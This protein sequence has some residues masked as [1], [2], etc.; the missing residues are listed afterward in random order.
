MKPEKAKKHLEARR[1]EKYDSVNLI[2]ASHII[3]LETFVAPDHEDQYVRVKGYE[4][5]E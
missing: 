1:Q 2:K 4:W 5:V 3:K